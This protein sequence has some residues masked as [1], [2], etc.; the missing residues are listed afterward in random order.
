[1]YTFYKKK[2]E[3]LWFSNGNKFKHMK[4]KIIVSYLKYFIW[5]TK[6]ANIDDN[7]WNGTV[8]V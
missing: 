5:K 3:N 7:T 8:C 1:M 6:C 4:N 2:V